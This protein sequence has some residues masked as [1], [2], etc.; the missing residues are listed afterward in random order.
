[1]TITKQIVVISLLLFSFTC[2]S[3]ELTFEEYNP[4]PTLV[5]PGKTI[6]RAKYPFIDIHGH[7]YRMSNQDLSPVVAAMDT[8]NMGIMINLS[9]R[10]GEDLQKSVANIKEHYP[11]RF[12]VFANIDFNGVGN[13]DWIDTTVNQLEDDVKHG[14]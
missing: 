8:L 1:M 12:V 4:N 3:Q 10:S 14:A 9:G 7:Q 5:V 11:N 6:N 2:I 13:K